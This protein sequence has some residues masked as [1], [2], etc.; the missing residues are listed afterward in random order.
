MTGSV[1][2]LWK[3]EI[4]IGRY[5]LFSF[6]KSEYRYF[7]QLV[8][9]ASGLKLEFN[10]LISLMEERYQ[11]WLDLRKNGIIN[12]QGEQFASLESQFG[13]PLVAQINKN[14]L[15]ANK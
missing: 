1:Y 15:S 5:E 8:T 14:A 12:D 11:A 10:S 3:M 4:N 7:Q 2:P 6:Y 9:E 13:S